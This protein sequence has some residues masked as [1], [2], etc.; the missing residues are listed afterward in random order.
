[1]KKFRIMWLVFSAAVL[2][3]FTL[4]RVNEIRITDS[5][6]P[7]I[8][9]ESGMLVVS[10]EDGEEALLQGITA[11]DKKDGDVTDSVIVEKI[12]NFYEDGKRI[13]TYAAFDSDNHIAKYEREI[14]YT[15][16]TPTRFSLTGSLRFRT[17]ETMDLGA[18]IRA[19]DCIDGDLS[20]KVKV[21]MD[22]NIN[23]RMPGRYNIE[24]Q[25]TNSAGAVAYLPVSVEVYQA[26]GWDA[27]LQLSEYLLYYDGS[28]PDYKSLLR[29]L[30]IGNTEYPFE[31]TA[32]NQPANPTEEPTDE[33]VEEPVTMISKDSVEV[34]S[35]VDPG[36][37]GAYPV[38]LVYS[39]DR[40]RATEMVIVVVEE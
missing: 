20:N 40:Y 28:E 35:Q 38:Y 5:S 14:K 17:G 34:I 23:N 29:S 37:P 13:V 39:G 18:I 15:D 2:V 26:D 16:Y 8:T 33:T 30:K 7:K 1:M 11:T 31:D 25:V 4:Y 12:S 3:V 10:I 32:G 27:K 36:K 22:S 6:G 9:C 19:K 21:Q 24:Y